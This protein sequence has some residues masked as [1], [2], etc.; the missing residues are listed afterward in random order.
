MGKTK[1]FTHTNVLNLSCN[2][3]GR[4]FNNC[5]GYNYR[6]HVD[7]SHISSLPP[8]ISA[9][10]SS[11]RATTW[12]DDNFLS[13]SY[14]YRYHVDSSHISSFPPYISASMSSCSATIW[15]DDN[16]LTSSLS[17]MLVGDKPSSA[18]RF[19]VGPWPSISLNNTLYHWQCVLT[20]SLWL[21]MDSAYIKLI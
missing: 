3:F 2:W 18:P 19:D 1:M 8:Y 6:D 14:N 21:V 13:S 10:M 12:Q 7:S 17:L 20:S 9:S 15:Q 11:C 16:S 4:Y 5:Y